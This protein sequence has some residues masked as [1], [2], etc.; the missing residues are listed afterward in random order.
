MLLWGIATI[1]TLRRFYMLMRRTTISH[2]SFKRNFQTQSKDSMPTSQGNTDPI[3]V[4][5]D[6]HS[7]SPDQ[8]RRCEIT[9]ISISR[10]I[11]RGGLAAL[12]R[13]TG[14]PY[15]SCLS[16]H[17]HPIR[18]FRA[19]SPRGEGHSVK[20]II[21]HVTSCFPLRG[22]CRRQYVQ[23]NWIFRSVATLKSSET[24]F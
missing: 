20:E 2:F 13:V 24:P 17:S 1:Y 6:Q 4:R 18:P 12:I 11:C 14:K 15:P 8:K 9:I 5:S 23:A 21:S 7:P 16:C 3:I 22:K 10:S 19:P